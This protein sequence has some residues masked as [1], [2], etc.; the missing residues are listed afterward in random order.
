M[1]RVIS[2]IKLS[3]S[4]DGITFTNSP[5]GNFASQKKEKDPKAS[6]KVRENPNYDNFRKQHIEFASVVLKAR[7]FR[8]LA[9]R[10]NI[11]AKEGSSAGRVNQ[12]LFSI[13][14]EDPKEKGSRTV[15]GGLATADAKAFILGFES[16]FFRPLSKVLKKK[17]KWDYKKQEFCLDRFIAGE[18]LDWPLGATHVHLAIVTENYETSIYKSDASYSEEIVLEKDAEQQSIRL[19]TLRPKGNN[20]HISFLFIGFACQERLSYKKLARIHNS[21]TVIAV[22]DAVENKEV[23][24]TDSVRQLSA[25]KKFFS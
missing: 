7:N 25:P 6:K 23:V 3:G 16:N 18:H 11:Y 2:P 10:F 20:L 19:T 21:T 17:L 1:A 24:I 13:L 8:M 15:E 14:S 9:N 4:I 12:L 22:Y 5:F